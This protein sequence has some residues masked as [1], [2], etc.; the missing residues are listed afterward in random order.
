MLIRGTAP[1]KRCPK[2]FYAIPGAWKNFYST[3]ITSRIFPR[4]VSPPLNTLQASLF[5]KFP[6]WLAELFPAQQAPQAWSERQWS[7]TSTVG[8]PELR[9]FG[10]AGRIPQWWVQYALWP[11]FPV[12]ECVSFANRHLVLHRIAL[13]LAPAAYFTVLQIRLN[14]LRLILSLTH[15]KQAKPWNQD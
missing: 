4:C 10:G 12:S 5:I 7:P 13:G 1:C 15:S 6:I 11:H 9:K 3:R 8:H 2:T 14:I